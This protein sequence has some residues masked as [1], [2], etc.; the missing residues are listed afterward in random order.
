MGITTFEPD[1]AG[2]GADGV[3]AE[4]VALG[5]GGEPELP[6]PEGGLGAGAAGAG[7]GAPE[8]P[9]PPAPP[10]IPEPPLVVMELSPFT[11]SVPG[12]GKATFSFSL[13][14]HPL[15]RLQVNMSGREPRAFARLAS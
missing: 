7:A 1:G 14:V 3:P 8:P 15:P 13:V 6:E 4:L 2:A 9:D 5:K 10:P 11:T 12:L